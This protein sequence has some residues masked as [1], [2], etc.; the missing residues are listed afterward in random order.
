MPG[1]TRK[2]G[3]RFDW[4]QL[5]DDDGGTASPN[6]SF[7]LPASLSVTA[8]EALIVDSDQDAGERDKGVSIAGLFRS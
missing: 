3:E 5:T 2:H 4:I 8:S 6:K 7:E 1:H